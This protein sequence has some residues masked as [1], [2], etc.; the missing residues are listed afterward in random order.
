MVPWIEWS[1]WY[2]WRLYTDSIAWSPSSWDW[3]S[4]CHWRISNLPAAEKNSELSVCHYSS[5]RPS[6]PL[7]IRLN[8]LDPY[9]PGGKMQLFSIPKLTSGLITIFFPIPVLAQEQTSED[10][11]NFWS[12]GMVSYV[13][14]THT[15]R[16]VYNKRRC[17]G[18]YVTKG[19]IGIAM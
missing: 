16:S 9:R 12:I 19:F 7:G 4:S 17:D 1:L 14:L 11:Q 3:C 5:R 18:R 10:L 15:N 8:G 2:D 6:Q 13:I